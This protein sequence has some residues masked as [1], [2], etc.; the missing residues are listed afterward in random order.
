MTKHTC[1]SNRKIGSSNRTL[2]SH[3]ILRVLQKVVRPAIKNEDLKHKYM[4]ALEEEAV[5]LEDEDKKLAAKRDKADADLSLG[6]WPGHSTYHVGEILG[7]G[8]YGT[9]FEGRHRRNGSVVAIKRID[10]LFSCK[11][12]TV[13]AMRE[14]NL[15]AHVDASGGRGSVTRLIEVIEPA[16]DDSRFDHMYSVYEKFDSNLYEAVR[17]S[18]W[19]SMTTAEKRVVAFK[20][21]VCVAG[22]HSCSVAHRDIKPENIVVKNGLERIALCDLGMARMARL[23]EPEDSRL[24]KLTDYVTTRWYRAPEVCCGM[25]SSTPERGLGMMAADVWSLGCVIGELLVD[26][27]RPL[28]CGDGSASQTRLIGMALGPMDVTSRQFYETYSKNKSAFES[29][30]QG[31]ELHSIGPIKNLS[32]M[33]LTPLA[34]DLLQKMLTYD[35]RKRISADAVLAHPFFGGLTSPQRPPPIASESS[36]IASNASNGSNGSNGSQ[37]SNASNASEASDASDIA[38]G[39]GAAMT[40]SHSQARHLV[41]SSLRHCNAN[42][43]CM[44]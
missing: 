37:A 23:V 13:S 9:V 24:S 36:D 43:S 26:N 42:L 12:V 31:A 2:R 17:T 20:L 33:G 25:A 16:A 1:Q 14:I 19:R 39:T 30:L 38:W 4:R 6:L 41:R 21:C 3:S 15:H 22:I 34:V 11:D 32:N 10:G 35:P 18:M 8:S 40:C 28:F 7:R 44:A 29:L 27:N 5:A